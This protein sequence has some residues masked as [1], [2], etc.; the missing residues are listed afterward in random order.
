MNKVKQWLFDR[1]WNFLIRLPG[2]KVTFVMN[3]DTFRS[4]SMSWDDVNRIYFDGGLP[5]EDEE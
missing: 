2:T 3:K 1:L 5:E 4:I